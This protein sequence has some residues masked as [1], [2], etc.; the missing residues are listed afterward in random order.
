MHRWFA[1]PEPFDRLRMNGV[2]GWVLATRPSTPGSLREPCARRVDQN[3]EIP[4]YVPLTLS[5]P[6]ASEGQSKGGAGPGPEQGVH[7]STPGSLRSPCAQDER[8]WVVI[9]GSDQPSRG[10]RTLRTR[11]RSRD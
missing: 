10:E 4:I 11:P 2:E 8:G 9:D 3:V 7:P 1:H 6:S 5:G